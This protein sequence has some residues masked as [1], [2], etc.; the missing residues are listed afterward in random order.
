MTAHRLTITQGST[1]WEGC[2]LSPHLQCWLQW[3]H[4]SE[5]E[6]HPT[7]PKQLLLK[8]PLDL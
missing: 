8:L 5:E 1:S 3:L 2:S 6:S 4:T 7:D